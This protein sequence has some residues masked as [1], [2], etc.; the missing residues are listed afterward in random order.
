MGNS[1]RIVLKVFL[2]IIICVILTWVPNLVIHFLEKGCLPPLPKL[3]ILFSVA[4]VVIVILF[5]IPNR[6]FRE[7]LS[8]I[9]KMLSANIERPFFG[10]W[11]YKVIRGRFHGREIIF[12]YNFWDPR[13]HMA[14]FFTRSNLVS[15]VKIGIIKPEVKIGEAKI[16]FVKGAEITKHT[17]YLN[18]KIW[19]WPKPPDWDACKKISLFQK[20]SEED[21]RQIFEELTKAAD[22]FESDSAK[23]I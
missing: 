9:V 22:I 17:C 5:Y 4:A 11:F 18:N 16:G 20:H 8:L 10:L 23:F 15:V 13:R 14:Y 6:I 19:Y 2:L 21:F 7:N 12:I 3:T 1:K